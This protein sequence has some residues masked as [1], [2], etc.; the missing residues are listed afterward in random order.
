MRVITYEC[1]DES[2]C[3]FVEPTYHFSIHTFLDRDLDILSIEIH[4]VARYSF[5]GMP[6]AFGDNCLAVRSARYLHSSA[7]PAVSLL[8]LTKMLCNNLQHSS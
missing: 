3:T 7:L 4:V 8:K 1:Q 6:Q 5:V 2:Y